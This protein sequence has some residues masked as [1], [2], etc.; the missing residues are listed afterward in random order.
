MSG[1]SF[2]PS[3][4]KVQNA[5]KIFTSAKTNATI[6]DLEEEEGEL[7]EKEGVVVSIK[8]DKINGAG[9]TVKDAEG[10]LYI[11]S[12]AS[13]MYEM[14]ETVERGGILYPT[15]NVEVVFTVNP[16]L[17][18]NTIKEIKS[19]GE[20]TEKIDISQWT[21]GD[22]ATTVIAKPKSALS[23]SDGLIKI[24]Y[25]N[26]NRILADPEG[27]KT[28]GKK[29]TID[30]EKLEINSYDIN[31]NGQTFSNVLSDNALNVSNQYIKYTLDSPLNTQVDRSNNITQLDIYGST[32]IT[33]K[34]VIGEIKDQKLIP[35]EEKSQRLVT[36]GD[37]TNLVTIDTDGIIYIEPF[38]NECPKEVSIK[39]LTQWLTPQ[40]ETRNYIKV[41]VKQICNNCD[42]WDN[43]EREFINYCPKCG[44]WACLY[45]APT[46]KI[47]CTRCSAEF[48]E[49]CGKELT[50]PSLR[51][52][53][54]ADN[55]V[56]AYGTTC[57]HCESQLTKGT[58]KYYVNYC[59]DCKTWGM[60]IRE[61]YYEND[62]IINVLRCMTCGSQYCCTCGVDQKVSQEESKLKLGLTLTNN[63][64]QY[65]T[66]KNAI[67]KLKYLKG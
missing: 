18:I 13:S 29:T 35:A 1:H 7:E 10:Q 46:S 17:R 22:E 63:P 67:R 37:C 27:V 52:R 8:R 40:I 23:I 33:E 24:D 53:D 16:V 55:Y 38:E 59:P 48:C 50:N 14:P 64:V 62:K 30:T 49:N 36:D 15:D 65:D 19:L 9:W 2:R 60:M 4:A 32:K 5:Q 6:R 43:T 66:Y 61:E 28:E 26:D 25:N 45:D 20:E 3:I 11:C 57:S 44:N 58:T 42:T 12:C 39:S 47:K 51:L 54:Y 34:Q 41:T 56:I 31:I 21:H